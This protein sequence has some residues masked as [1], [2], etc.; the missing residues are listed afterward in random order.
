MAQKEH[1]ERQE[2]D[3]KKREYAD[4]MSSRSDRDKNKIKKMLKVTKSANRSVLEDAVNKTDT[5]VTLQGPEQPDEDDYGYTS[6]EASTF[7]RNLMD[8]YKSIPEDKNFSK[9]TCGGSR[10]VDLMST[11]DRVRAAIMRER[12]D[13]MSGRKRSHGSTASDERHASSSID[14]KHRSRKNLYDPKAERD[15]EER[16]KKELE[17]ERRQ[18]MRNK[19]PPP[20]IMD[21]Q[22]L[23]QIAAEKQHEP[24][25]V[26]VPQKIKEP[27]RLLTNKEK[28][29]ME[30]RKA[31]QEER[32][33]RRNGIPTKS[34]NDS[35]QRKPAAPM[36]N[37]RIPKLNG[38]NLCSTKPST[39][40]SA[41]LDSRKSSILS[42]ELTKPAPSKPIIKP[43]SS[44]NGQLP[45]KHQLQMS[46]KPPNLPQ[47]SGV[48]RSIDLKSK[49][50]M[51]DMQKSLPKPNPLSK[52]PKAIDSKTVRPREFPPKDL[53]KAREFPPRDLAKSKP[54][55][56]RDVQ[57]G[58]M[59]MKHKQTAAS[60]RRILDDSDE[61]SDYDSEMDDFIDDGPVDNDYSNEI[62]KIF[63]YDKSRYRDEDDDIDNMESTFAQQQ[64]EE[65]I[66]KKIGLLEDLEDMRQEAEEKK[67]KAKRRRL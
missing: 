32:E 44:S 62:Q 51:H 11:K 20:P 45:S 57:R 63:G 31:Q 14:D 3:K 37:G 29:E 50:Q 54:F 46:S 21:F 16:R 53:V 67:R 27:E 60:K 18:K 4:L 30:M 15:A 38:T 52:Q 12:E 61:E 59:S 64:K 24:I 40:Q 34:P 7:Y 58:H 1:E 33:R 42:R 8:K 56:P 39:P 43:Q 47:S 2:K 5:A 41:P 10:N 66:S 36:A 55:P 35:D 17:D 49:N 6:T 25:Q 9:S 26:E 23:L 19:R 48:K 65:F 22:K 13:E 28:K